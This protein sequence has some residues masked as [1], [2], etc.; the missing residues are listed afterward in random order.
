M[1]TTPIA[2]ARERP[3]SHLKK[4]NYT[5]PAIAAHLRKKYTKEEAALLKREKSLL[6]TQVSKRPGV[7]TSGGE[8]KRNHSNTIVAA[9]SSGFPNYVLPSM[10]WEDKTLCA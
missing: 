7:V 8:P 9:T 1:S 3:K 2:F 5:V 10:S 4:Y 6:L